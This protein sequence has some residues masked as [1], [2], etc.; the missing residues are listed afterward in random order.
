MK[1]TP[2][3]RV[4]RKRQALQPAYNEFRQT[5]LERDGHICQFY[6]YVLDSP[7]W[8]SA[9]LANVPARC[10]GALEVHH[11]IP[12]SAWPEGVQVESNCVTLCG[13]AHHPWVTDNPDKAHR[14]GLHGFSWERPS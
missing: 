13:L 5:I 12:R 1:R 9:D 8:R 3:R 4:S 7:D 10:N 11:I 14:V 6:T 2:L